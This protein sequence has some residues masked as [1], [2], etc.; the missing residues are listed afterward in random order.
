MEELQSELFELPAN[1]QATHLASIFITLLLNS[2]LGLF[3]CL[4]IL[5]STEKTLWDKAS[6]KRESAVYIS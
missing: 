6:T 3:E 4:G 2:D 5:T 1:E